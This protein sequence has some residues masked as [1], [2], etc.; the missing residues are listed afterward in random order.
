MCRHVF[1][2]D[3]DDGDKKRDRRCDAFEA[4][5][6]VSDEAFSKWAKYVRSGLP[7]HL[8]E[9]SC[10]ILEHSEKSL[11]ELL[12]TDQTSYSF[13][14]EP[15][16]QFNQSATS[17]Y[18]YSYSW[19][20]FLKRRAQVGE[21][22]RTIVKHFGMKYQEWFR[23][24][25]ELAES[26]S[27][28]QILFGIEFASQG[29]LRLKFYFQFSPGCLEKKSRILKA[30]GIPKLA[31]MPSS[32]L[33]RL[34]LLGIDLKE[35]GISCTKLYFLHSSLLIDEIEQGFLPANLSDNALLRFLKSN[36]V[37]EII[38]FLTIMRVDDPRDISSVDESEIDFSLRK[39]NIDWKLIKTFI[40]TN[41]LAFDFAVYEKLK[42]NI[43]VVENR[44]SVPVKSLSKMTIY[45]LLF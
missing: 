37:A 12:K 25:V 36:G 29:C 7:V 38:D 10:R 17:Y 20:E 39:N 15:S 34:H 28:E 45:Y 27:A 24:L 9:Q 18:R 13:I 11:R 33:S 21:N 43:H 23:R 14:F 16:L 41:S 1:Y 31:D 19:P 6:E 35:N 22:I 42:E 40:I 26:E 3:L 30:L 4:R 32:K 2:C 5:K 44:I 8:T